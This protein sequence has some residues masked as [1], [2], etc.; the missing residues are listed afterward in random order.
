MRLV[1]YVRVSTDR[2]AGK[3]LGLDMQEALIRRWAKIQRH[4]LLR[5]YVD[6]SVSEGD[7]LE[8]RLGLAEALETLR[9][10]R[11]K[12]IVVLRLDR[13]AGN[14]IQ[15]EQLQAEVRRLGGAVFSTDS[16]EAG[17]LLDD[18]DEP[19]RKLIREVLG[20]VPAYERAMTALRLRLERHRGHGSG[21]VADDSPSYSWTIDRWSPL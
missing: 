14:L 3:G 15:Q 13:L 16:A 5:I 11:A 21:G 19:S 12:G 18:P 17:H 2:P 10:G 20:A 7:D 9:T 4:K 6:E 1:G 8:T